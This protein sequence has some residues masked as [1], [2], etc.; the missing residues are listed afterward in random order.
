MLPFVGPSYQLATRK[1]AIDRAVNMYLV[2]METP[3]K[4]PWILKSIPGLITRWSLSGEVRGCIEVG[5]RA[6]AV[7]GSTLYEL[8]SDY[9]S[10]ALGTLSTS[11]GTVDMAYGLFQLVMVDG[12]NGYVLQLSSSTFQ[13]ITDP[14]WPGSKTVRFLDNYF[15]FIHPDT[16][17]A[18]ISAIND[19]TDFDALDFASAESSPDLLVAQAVLNEQWIQFGEL[20]TEFFRDFGTAD[21]PFERSQGTTLQVGCQAVYSVQEV[22]SS[23]FFIGRDK[24]GSGMVY[25]YS[26]GQDQRI[27]TQAVEQAL[28]A[29]TDLSSATSYAY[30]MDGR[31]FYCVNAPGVNSTWCYEVASSSWHERCD[32]DS[33]G[34]FA[35]HRAV[36]HL[37]AFSQHFV[38]AADGRIYELNRDTYTNAGDSLVRERISPHEAIPGRVRQTFTAF[39]LD[40]TTGEAPQGEDPK[41]E[42][43]FSNDSGARWS[44][45][46]LRSIG[47]VGERFARV[48]WT[49]LGMSRDRVWKL[50][51]SGNAPFDII[52]AGADAQKGTN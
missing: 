14:D 2:A 31:T 45:S 40:C 41:V 49:R 50:R 8:F 26:S 37:H 12:T 33:L 36:R 9:T 16:Q 47:K 38:G 19:A 44:N 10:T 43:S 20:S 4:A 6:F 28:Q 15:L 17:Q 39:Y 34:Q 35:Q 27:S 5:T 18:F 23:V 11:T 13:T 30:Q 25:R 22:D 3:G 32:L 46:I 21:Y 1:A 42:L 52:D 24:N 29:S 7:A 48:L 51:F